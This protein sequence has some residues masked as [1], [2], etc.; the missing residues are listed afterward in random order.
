[1]GRQ[2]G[3]RRS[4]DATPP[5]AAGREAAVQGS[6]KMRETEQVIAQLSSALSSPRWSTPSGGWMEAGVM[7]GWIQGWLGKG[8]RGEMLGRRGVGKRRGYLMSVT[9][10]VFQCETSPLK[11]TAR[12]NMPLQ[13]RAMKE[14]SE[15]TD[16]QWR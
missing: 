14:Q 13:A 7:H 10:A 11:L 4:L 12:W 1:M 3:A 16:P 5:R 6:S 15:R 9:A 8:E 2:G